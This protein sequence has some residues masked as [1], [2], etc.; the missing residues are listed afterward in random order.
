MPVPVMSAVRWP[1]DPYATRHAAWNQYAIRRQVRYHGLGRGRGC[2]PALAPPIIAMQLAFLPQRESEPRLPTYSI[3]ASSTPDTI[4]APTPPPL[5]LAH[6]QSV[7]V[8]LPS[9]SRR[10]RSSFRRH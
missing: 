5:Y 1:W 8:S 7:A 9:P 10:R 6:S 4:N 3:F 2:T